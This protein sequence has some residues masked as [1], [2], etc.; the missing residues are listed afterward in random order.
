MRAT[1]EMSVVMYTR[2]RRKAA[3]TGGAHSFWKGYG[4]ESIRLR[5][6]LHR[7]YLRRP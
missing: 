4:H 6:K 1:Y 5:M 7:M 2:K 3:W